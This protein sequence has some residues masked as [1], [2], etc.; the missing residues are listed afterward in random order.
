MLWMSLC[1]H[2]ASASLQELSSRL[3]PS[4]VRQWLLCH[5][6][7]SRKLVLSHGC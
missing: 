5:D 2:A 6:L 7:L 4:W 3:V 1:R